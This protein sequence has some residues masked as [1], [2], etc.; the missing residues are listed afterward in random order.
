ME[1]EQ[2]IVV[3]IEIE[4]AALAG[5]TLARRAYFKPHGL[6]LRLI[7]FELGVFDL[8]GDMV[9]APRRQRLAF[10]HRDPEIADLE[11]F[12]AGDGECAFAARIDF[13]GAENTG[14][15][16]RHPLQIA[17]DASHVRQPFDHSAAS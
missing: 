10:H 16:A 1:L 2:M 12:L 14:Q 17:D 3:V 5:Y 4:R 9:I 13:P 7:G 8:E 11:E 15:D 6:D